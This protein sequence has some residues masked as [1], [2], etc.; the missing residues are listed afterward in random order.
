MPPA[1]EAC[2][3]AYTLAAMGCALA[4]WTWAG[5]SS[6]V[7]WQLQVNATIPPRLVFTYHSDLLNADE[8]SLS[9]RDAALAA[10][11]RNTIRLH[12]GAT[13]HFYDDAACVHVLRELAVEAWPSDWS[14]LAQFFSSEEEGA[15]K[16]DMCR[17]A[18]LYLHGG[19]YFDIDMVSRF[20]VR[21]LI[22]PTS[23]FV[24]VHAARA[25]G[26]APSFFDSFMAISRKHAVLRRTLDLV[27]AYYKQ[28]LKVSGWMGCALLYRAYHDEAEDAVSTAQLWLEIERGSRHHEPVVE[29]DGVGCCCNMLV[30]DPHTDSVP[31]YSRLVGFK[32]FCALRDGAALKPALLNASGLPLL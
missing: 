4:Y 9:L 18:A 32:R 5:R 26:E 28:Q 24:T 6:R 16:G 13:V 12:P 27:V 23:T 7:P 30:V 8:T 21:T 10:N 15:Y 14:L 25:H 2:P 19:L 3:L 11:V 20:D 22:E 17:F 1:H 29:Q 31:F